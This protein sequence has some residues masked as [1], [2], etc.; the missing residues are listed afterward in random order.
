MADLLMLDDAK[1][2]PWCGY[3]F[4][5][6][7]LA[8]IVVGE[9]AYGTVVWT[10]GGHVRLE[11]EESGLVTIEELGLDPP[12]PGVW[13][14]EGTHLWSPGPWEYPQDGDVELIGKFRLPTKSEWEALLRGE[15]P[16]D[17]AEWKV[18]GSVE[19]AEDAL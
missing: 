3:N 19:P 8:V 9:N 6:P 14:W 16:W 17:D 5:K 1:G 10:V 2:E 13:V 4:D 12:G 11:M 7:S 15:C 18:P